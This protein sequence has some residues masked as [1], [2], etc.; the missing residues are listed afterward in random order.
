MRL[1]ILPLFLAF[2][3]QTPGYRADI[4]KFRA[5]RADEISGATG[6]AALVG[7]HWITNLVD[8]VLEVSFIALFFGIPIPIVGTTIVPLL[9]TNTMLFYAA[10]YLLISNLF[11]S[12]V[13]PFTE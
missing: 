12:I 5:E 6:W 7:L 13:A 4:E 10:A 9:A 8:I 1:L 3:F 2:T 11:W